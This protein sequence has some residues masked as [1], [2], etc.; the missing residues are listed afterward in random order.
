M[1]KGLIELLSSD[2]ENATELGKQHQNFD[3]N[4]YWNR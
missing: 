4:I 1:W 3:N 2:F